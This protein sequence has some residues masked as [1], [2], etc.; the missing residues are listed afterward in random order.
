MWNHPIHAWILVKELLKTISFWKVTESNSKH[1]NIFKKAYM[2]AF[3]HITEWWP[4][5]KS[6]TQKTCLMSC[7]SNCQTKLEIQSFA[8]KI[9]EI[10]LLSK[11]KNQLSYLLSVTHYS[12]APASN[13]MGFMSYWQPISSGFR[14]P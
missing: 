4:S 12:V 7:I 5:A 9:K 14:N 3:S 10:Y 6:A 1:H 2:W 11:E 13:S 8:K